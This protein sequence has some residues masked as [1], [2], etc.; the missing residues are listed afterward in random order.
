MANSRYLDDLGHI[1]RCFDKTTKL[2]FSKADEPQYIK[3]GSN[4]DNDATHNIRFGQLKLLGWVISSM[5]Y[6]IVVEQDSYRTDVASFFEPSV[7]C[8]VKAI[9]NE[10]MS[11][12]TMISVSHVLSI[13]TGLLLTISSSDF[14]MLFSLVALQRVIGSS[15]K[16]MRH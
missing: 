2:R 5:K 10:R 9:L 4:R 8:I 1:V 16:Y 6:R 12:P 11:T 14:S 13:S 7:D 3:F 15:K